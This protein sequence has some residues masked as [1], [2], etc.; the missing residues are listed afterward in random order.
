[1]T[2]NDSNIPQGPFQLPRKRVGFY[3]K[4]GVLRQDRN[5]GAFYT[6][7]RP[8]GQLLDVPILPGDD[9]ELG[10]EEY[11]VISRGHPYRPDPFGQ[12]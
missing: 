5:T 8:E 4:I 11:W 1:M 7:I 9:I 3:G 12:K 6:R 10:D 2:I